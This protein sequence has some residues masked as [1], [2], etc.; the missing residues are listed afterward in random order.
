MKQLK[1]VIV[2][3]FIGAVQ[4]LNAQ[5]PGKKTKDPYTSTDGHTY[6]VDEILKVNF[7]SKGTDYQS[8][9]LY[10]H[11][12][13]LESTSKFLNALS[14]NSVSKS[15]VKLANKEI[16]SFSGK[17]LYFKVFKNEGN[18]TTY[19]IVDYKNEYRLA[20][21]IDYAVYL[22]ELL[23]NNPEY[24]NKTEA[25]NLVVATSNELSVK[26]FHPNFLL[27]LVS[28]EGNTND[29]TVTL[30]YLVSHKMVHQNVCL[31]TESRAKLFDYN[32]NEYNAKT[33]IVANENNRKDYIKSGSAF[34]NKIPTNVPVKL[35]VVFN[36][37]LPSNKEFSYSE[38]LVFFKDFDNDD[39]NYN[40]G[41]I[42]VNNLKVQWK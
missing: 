24:L 22:K 8:I 37:V 41:N 2:F 42:E 6:K 25:D 20:I 27:K 1:T 31:A 35:I 5:F 29:Q 12:D 18:S 3:L 28:A 23:S 9:F 14:G 40:I 4:L 39:Y 11:D 19:A 32:G 36:K 21:P 38:S 33:V 13:T 30:T 17:I 15:D 16:N 10:K 7:P 34:C 26:S